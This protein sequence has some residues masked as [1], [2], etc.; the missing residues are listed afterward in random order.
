M[1]RSFLGLEIIKLHDLEVIRLYLS[2]AG[3]SGKVAERTAVHLRK[4]SVYFYRLNGQTCAIGVMAGVLIFARYCSPD[5]QFL[6]LL[7][8][9]EA[10]NGPCNYGILSSL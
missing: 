1:I 10:P 2:K 9:R 5:R 4:L 8:K 7:V 3:F 6:C